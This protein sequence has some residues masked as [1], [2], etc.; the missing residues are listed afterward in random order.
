MKFKMKK[1]FLCGIVLLVLLPVFA[2]AATINAAS[3]NL[4]DVLAAINSAQRGDTVNVPAGS[5][6]WSTPLAITKGMIIKGAGIDKTVI[7]SGSTSI[8]TYSPDSVSRAND[9]RFEVS[10]FT[11]TG[12]SSE[13]TAC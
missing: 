7:T 10:G 3:C 8:I 5:C 1:I 6:I 13:V 4:A 9:D 12:S 11:F 2:S